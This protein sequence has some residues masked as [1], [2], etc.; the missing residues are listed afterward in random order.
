MG[1][2]SGDLSWIASIIS[3]GQVG[4]WFV[5]L[6]WDPALKLSHMLTQGNPWYTLGFES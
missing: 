1:A 2:S 6:R 5:V 3:V 4:S